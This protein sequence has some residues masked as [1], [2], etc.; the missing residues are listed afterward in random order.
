MDVFKVGIIKIPRLVLARCYI[1]IFLSNMFINKILINL[2]FGIIL[3]NETIVFEIFIQNFCMEG[4]YFP[5]FSTIPKI[6]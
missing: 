6:N 5:K 2:Q 3:N 4:T 1:Y